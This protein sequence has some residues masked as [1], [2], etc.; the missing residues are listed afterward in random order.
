MHKWQKLAPDYLNSRG[1]LRF[2]G[3]TRNA[4]TFAMH[5]SITENGMEGGRGLHNP[6]V[7]HSSI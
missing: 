6:S 1:F 4:V 3:A 5:G 7:T 2:L